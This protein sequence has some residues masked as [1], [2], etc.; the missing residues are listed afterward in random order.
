MRISFF[1]AVNFSVV[2]LEV[3]FGVEL[4]ATCFTWKGI[5][6]VLEMGDSQM[7]PHEMPVVAFEL[8]NFTFLR[9]IQTDKVQM[10][11]P[12][13]TQ[14]VTHQMPDVLF[15]FCKLRWALGT[16]ME[17]A[18]MLFSDMLLVA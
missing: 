18:T 2:M 3:R 9:L 17:N 4:L 10:T 16:K 14:I 7:L 13:Q 1:I 5:S 12:L 11:T 6:N 15:F 8:A